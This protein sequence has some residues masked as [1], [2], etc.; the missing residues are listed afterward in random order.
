M[1]VINSAL[2]NISPSDIFPNTLFTE[3]F[4][5]NRRAVLALRA[6]SFTFTKSQVF[7]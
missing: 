6:F 7:L 5:R 1:T 2:M 4:P 3:R